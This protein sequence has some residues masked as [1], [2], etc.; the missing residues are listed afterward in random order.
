VLLALNENAEE[1]AKKLKLLG[2]I[3]LYEIGKLS[4][5]KT[6]ELAGIDKVDFIFELGKYN[7]P[8]I[9]YSLESLKEEIGLVKDLA[10]EGLRD[11]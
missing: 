4:L 9:R 7:V 8:V 5:G 2:A 1:F 3:K 11:L 6:A 10:N